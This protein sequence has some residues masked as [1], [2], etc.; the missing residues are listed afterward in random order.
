[1]QHAETTSI[2]VDSF[3]MIPISDRA[4][5]VFMFSGQGSQYYEMARGYYESESVFRQWMDYLDNLGMAYRNPSI[6]KEI[7]DKN[8][9]KG[10]PFSDIRYT[11]LGLFIVQYS[12]ART[13]MEKGICPDLVFGCSLG[14]IVAAAVSGSISV[15][16]ALRLVIEQAGLFRSDC[17]NGA[18]LAVLASE[19]V[20][21]NTPIMLNQSDIAAYNSKEHFVVAGKRRNIENISSHLELLGIASQILD[22]NTAFHSKEL[23]VVRAAFAELEKKYILKPARIP[24]ISS[25]YSSVLE[26]IPNIYLWQVLRSPINF[27]SA[28][29]AL[30][31]RGSFNFIDIGPSATLHALGK[32][33]INDGSTILPAMSMFGDD[34]QLLKK[35]IKHFESDVRW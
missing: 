18:M 19:D 35:I 27:S 6:I 9:A 16:S 24:L 8:K 31:N 28:M 30:N 17:N 7:Y 25:A 20:Y 11:H 12:L 1:M 2:N 5:T 23:D 21:H 22:V 15:E 34:Q 3:S 4:K 10:T 29:T 14:E 32:K 13:L 33:Y 26:N